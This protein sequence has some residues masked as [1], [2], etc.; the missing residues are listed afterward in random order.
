VNIAARK[1]LRHVVTAL[2]H[3]VNFDRGMAAPVPGDEFR[4]K[5]LYDLGRRADA[6]YSSRAGLERACAFAERLDFH[7]QPAAAPQEVFALG[8]EPNAA[9]DAIE[10][11]YAE[12]CFERVDLPGQSRLA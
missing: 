4:E 6:E 11:R 5:V 9:A 2:L 7:Q 8:R 12:L 3:E 10:E 1:A